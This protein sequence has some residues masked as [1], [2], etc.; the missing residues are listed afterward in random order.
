MTTTSRSALSTVLCWIIIVAF[1]STLL[2]L[3]ARKARLTAAAAASNSVPNLG[4]EV[5]GRLA[6][7]QTDLLTKDTS[8][9]GQKHSDQLR[10]QLRVNLEMLAVSPLDK[11][12][13][14]VVIRELQ[15][16]QAALQELDADILAFTAHPLIL[17]DAQSLRNIYTNAPGINAKN[18]SDH[19]GWFGQLALTQGLPADDPARVA[20]LHVAHQSFVM[21]IALLVAM[22]LL[23]GLGF[24]LL[25][26]LIVLFSLGK[27]RFL[28]QPAPATGPPMFLESF[29]MWGVTYLILSL[30]LNRWQ[31]GHSPL[32]FE[33]IFAL[34]STL[35]AM[36]PMMRGSTWPQLRQSLGW[37]TGRGV[38]VE[39]GAGAL[40]YLAGLP[41]L[42]VGVLI[43][44]VLSKIGH[45]NPTHPI[46]QELAGHLSAGKIV[47][48]L[49]TISVAAPFLEETMFRGA[50]YFHLRRRWRPW[51]SAGLV[52]FIF[53]AIHPQGWAAIPMLGSIALTLAMLREWRGSLVASITAHGI[54]NAIV[55][56]AVILILR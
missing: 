45:A 28:F 40:G 48:L 2:V 49:I 8:P 14:I 27:L 34:L 25:I 13:V 33:L 17:A 26:L 39:I 44:L 36:W 54:N 42:G 50:L 22:V 10:T 32:L 51:L 53:A 6:V 5:A 19:L 35:V 16:S 55:L 38:F 47:S 56:F 20:A 12:K 9:A 18:L 7:A 4:L 37:H 29:A 11:L 52:A 30:I 41:I 46:Q 24:L 43:T 1:V 23:L 3:Q 21:T 31:T 15:G